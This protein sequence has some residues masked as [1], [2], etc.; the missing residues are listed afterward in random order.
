MKRF[1]SHLISIESLIIELDKMDLSE[2][3]RIHL[4]ELID[5]NLHHTIMDAI[6]S[7]L[8]EEDKRLFLKH[9]HDDDHDKVW[10]LLNKRVDNIE[11][12]I[13][14]AAESLK[15]EMHK[16]IKEAHTKQG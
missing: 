13:K 14:Q 12:K 16:D 3:E 8:P 1:Y 6:L 7:H 4:A 15:T 2:K 5:A 10:E 11:D 9:L